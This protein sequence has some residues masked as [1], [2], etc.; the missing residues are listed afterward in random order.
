MAFV[1]THVAA[2]YRP[3]L[4]KPATP[5]LSIVIPTWNGGQQL[6]ATL[7]HLGE[8]RTRLKFQTEIVIVDDCSGHSTARI[9]GDFADENELTV[10]LRNEMNQGKGHS[11]ARG[12][13]HASGAYRIFV[14]SDLAYPSCQITKLLRA[15]ES[16]SEVAIACRVLPESRYVMSPTFFH[17]LYTRHLM[18]RVFNRLAQQVLLPGILDTQ[19]GLKGF[20]AHAAQTIFSRQTLCGFGF[21]LECLFIARLHGLKIEQVPVDFYYTDEPSTISFAR[22][23]AEMLMDLVRVRRN[24]ARGI[25]A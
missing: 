21:D 2:R 18:S 14:D 25:Y 24:G 15:L 4:P 17:Y 11:V 16:G 1:E 3:G 9:A 7:T 10:V 8:F 19:A 20:T 6:S 13:L 23:G 12:M 22:H 5:H